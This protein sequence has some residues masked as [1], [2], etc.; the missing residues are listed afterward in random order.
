MDFEDIK[1][2]YYASLRTMNA[3]S[4]LRATVWCHQ[5]TA[6]RSIFLRAVSKLLA[7]L[8]KI[9]VPFAVEGERA[10]SVHQSFAFLS[11]AF[12]LEHARACAPD[13][14]FRE[15]FEDQLRDTHSPRLQNMKKR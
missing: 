9:P 10:R 2:Y 15:S 8:L 5:K 12:H 3:Y 11:F 14:V 4:Y 6:R 1:F 13:N 7:N